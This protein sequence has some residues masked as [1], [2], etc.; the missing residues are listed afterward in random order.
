MTNTCEY[1]RRNGDVCGEP[2]VERVS[3][4]WS[5]QECID[6]ISGQ[7]MG[8]ARAFAAEAMDKAT[9]PEERALIQDRLDSYKP[10]Q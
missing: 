6:H 4:K 3:G 10:I 1:L 2:A 9:T 5:C 7:L 8:H